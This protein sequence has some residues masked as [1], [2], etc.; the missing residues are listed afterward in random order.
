[1]RVFREVAY[2]GSI[3]KAAEKLGYVQSNVTAHIQ[4]LEAELTTELFVRHSKGVTLTESGQLL[5]PVADQVIA[6]LDNTKQQLR[7][8]RDSLRIGA[9]Q[10]IAACRLPQWLSAYRQT[11]PEVGLSVV[12]KTQGELLAAVADGVLHGAFVNTE[13]SH[14][15]LTTVLRF[16]EPLVLVAGPGSSP[17]RN[18]IAG[19]SIIVASIDGCPY[20]ALL[21][22]WSIR[23]NLRQ[24]EVI[25]F[26]TMEGILRAVSLGM[27]ITLLP[28]V[29]LP[30]VHD[31]HLYDAADIGQSEIQLVAAQS[32]S[33]QAASFHA[34]AEL[35]RGGLEVGDVW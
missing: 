23:H 35:V 5:L 1:M 10:T 34:F 28:R 21:E 26:D 25:R 3:S 17:D 16:K 13:W 29:V 6:L 14:P 30:L 18:Q 2:E 19:Q 24:P 4:R 20:R 27:G 12:T 9:T 8:Q 11:Y 7:H 15:Q 33:P 32:Q 22:K 31:L